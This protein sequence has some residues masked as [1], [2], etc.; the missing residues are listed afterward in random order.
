[1]FVA[2]RSERIALR[3]GSD[4]RWID[5]GHAFRA[6]YFERRRRYE[7]GPVEICR[8]RIAKDREGDSRCGAC[9]TGSERLAAERLLAEDWLALHS[10]PES[11]DGLRSHR[12][13]LHRGDAVCGCERKN[14]CGAG[15]K[16]RRI[17]RVGPGRGE[18]NVDCKRG[19]AGLER[20]FSNGWRRDLLWN[21]GG[22]V[23]SRE[24]AHRR[25]ALEVQMRVGNHWAAGDLYRGGRKTVCS[26]FVGDW[27]LVRRDCD[28]RYGY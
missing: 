12:G 1:M 24:R 20:R 28:W 18:E 10:A 8:G 4:E 13:E 23:Q 5:F 6:C 3:A 22:V 21:N 11:F 17:V 27:R 14:V 7:D 19:F 16:S 25:C 26:D 9:F 15:G 2:S